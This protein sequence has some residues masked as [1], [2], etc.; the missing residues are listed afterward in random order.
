[1]PAGRPDRG[2]F[3]SPTLD[4]SEAGMLSYRR[5]GGTLRAAEYVL[6]RPRRADATGRLLTRAADSTRQHWWASHQGHTGGGEKAAAAASNFALGAGFM[7]HG[8]S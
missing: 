6:R 7:R 5:R 8:A 2:A 4:H 3:I 1:M